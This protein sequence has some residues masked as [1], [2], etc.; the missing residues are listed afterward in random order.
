MAPRP[1][2]TIHPASLSYVLKESSRRG[3]HGESVCRRSDRSGRKAAGAAS[4]RRRA[5]D[6][7]LTSRSDPR[8]DEDVRKAATKMTAQLNEAYECLSDPQRRA[9]YDTRRSDDEN[10][11]PGHSPTAPRRSQ[12]T[13]RSGRHH[14]RHLTTISLGGVVASPARADLGFGPFAGSSTNQSAPDRCLMRRYDGRHHMAARLQPN[15]AA[16]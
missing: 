11:P 7:S 5:R 9:A 6:A 12:G 8:S 16:A 4:G 1:S 15:A 2:V 13:R 14:D 3:V 10:F